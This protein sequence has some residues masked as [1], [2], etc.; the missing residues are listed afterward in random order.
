MKP[1]AFQTEAFQDPEE[2]SSF[3]YWSLVNLKVQL[4]GSLIYCLLQHIVFRLANKTHQPLLL[5]RNMFKET[6]DIPEALWEFLLQNEPLELGGF[7]SCVLLGLSV[8][9]RIEG[10]TIRGILALSVPF[11]LLFSPGGPSRP[12]MT[13]LVPTYVDTMSPCQRDVV[14]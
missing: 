6:V 2:Y 8:I 11:R 13:G 14:G 3:F 12:H 4:L 7:R 5:P 1:L 10:V 9:S